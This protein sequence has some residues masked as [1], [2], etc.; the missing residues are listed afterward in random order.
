[1][2]ADASIKCRCVNSGMTGQ[3]GGFQ[4]RGFCLQVA[5]SKRSDSGERCEVKKAI[6]SRGGL[7]F[8]ALLFT[9]HRSP[10][11]ERLEQA[12][13]QAFPSFLPHPLP[14]ILLA[15]FFARSLTLVPRSLL[16]NRTETLATQANLFR[17]SPTIE[18]PIVSRHVFPLHSIFKLVSNNLK[19][20]AKI[21]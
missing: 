14:A 2:T 16:L 19:R 6:K 20:K 17:E 5:C 18:W 11:S 9:S 4:N 10:L 7:A 13:L 15:S 8:F 21:A 1:M 12:S 3:V